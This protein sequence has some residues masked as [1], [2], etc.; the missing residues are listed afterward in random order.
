[1][2][3]K[4]IFSDH[5]QDENSVSKFFLHTAKDNKKYNTMFYSLEMILSIGY[6]VNSNKAIEFRQ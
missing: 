1:M 5:E 6:R 4:S 3:I 2:H